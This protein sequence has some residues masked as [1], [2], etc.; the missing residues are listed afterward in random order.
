M[1]SIS[2]SF[3]SVAPQKRAVN[4]SKTKCTSQT[5]VSSRAFSRG[6]SASF[7]GE[8]VS[9]ARLTQKMN[10]SNRGQRRVT[11]MAAKVAGYIKLA[12]E[13]G[14]ANPAPPIGPALGA[15]GVNIMA[16]CKEYNARTSDQ[17]GMIIP[18]E[19][20]VFEDKSFTFILKTPPASVLLKKAAG[21]AK[22]AADPQK[23]N[24][25]SVTLAQLEEIAKIK[26]PDLNCTKVESA[27]EVVRGTAN[28]M[29]ISVVEA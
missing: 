14:K 3:V 18:V 27:M 4:P 26:L 9:C 19:I 17:P 11:T 29:G 7:S 8:S 12:I 10:G 6:T 16:F 23:Q 28:N 24:V 5:S 2:A 20:T 15:K 1:A 25:G 13:A 21:V 22:G